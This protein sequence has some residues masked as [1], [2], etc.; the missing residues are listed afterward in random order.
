MSQ[1]KLR[2]VFPGG[3]TCEGF[4]S[5]YDYIIEPD[6]N[7]IFVVK[8]G[9]G[10]GKSTFMRKIGETMLT[11]GYD[12]EFHC[13]SS[14][15]NSLDAV[16][17]P[18]IKVALIDGTAP[19]IVD[20][21]NPGA[22]DEIIHLG[23]YWD[24]SKIAAHKEEIIKANTRVSRLFQIAYSALR[25]AKVI[26]DEWESYISECMI[27]SQVNKAV[28]NLLQAIFNGVA[29]RYDRPAKTRHLF[30]TAI[31]P[32]G[33]ITG[34]VESL[35]QD[36]QQL[37]TISGEPGSGVAQVLARIAELAHE[38]GLH[39]EIYHCPFN[40]R[41]IDLVI[42]PE[43]K[44][45]AM[46]VQPPH[47][48]DPSSLPELMAMKLNLTAYI[49]RDKLGTYAHEISSAAYRYQACLDRA[50]AYIRQAKLT[51]DYIESFYI[52]AM[53]FE[54]INAKRQEVLQRI[55]NYAAEFSGN[56]ALAG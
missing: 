16:V 34:H 44:T 46:N 50:V 38:K 27:E 13:C 12:V 25:E 37:Y 54:A 56:H 11:K 5:F 17:I 43:I 4:Y 36:V 51:H 28:A 20:P 7:R 19:H 29:P 42:I 32:D 39:T 21:K 3:N 52:P 6:A 30:A 24:E 9:P 40:P 33:I 45:A 26:R 10:V 18:A 49:D 48:Y 23:D 31:T 35:L 8:G 41:N 55:L 15:N 1:G 2:R 47:T 22:V 53:N 14:D